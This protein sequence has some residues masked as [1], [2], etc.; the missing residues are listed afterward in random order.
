MS[1]IIGIHL[2]LWT[3]II[4]CI[5]DGRGSNSKLTTDLHPTVLL[6]CQCSHCPVLSPSNHCNMLMNKCHPPSNKGL[7]F[8]CRNFIAKQ[9]PL[10]LHPGIV[11][12]RGYVTLVVATTSHH[13]R[14]VTALRLHLCPRVQFGTNTTPS[15]TESIRHCTTFVFV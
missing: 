5:S 7:L 12:S 9:T 2:H 11:R 6:Q 10:L 14:S 13:S 4:T 8:A 3:W 1:I 15:D